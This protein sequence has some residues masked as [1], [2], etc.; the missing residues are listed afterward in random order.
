ML[1]TAPQAGI[2]ANFSAW[3]ME[4]IPGWEGKGR[5]MA[6]YTPWY[7]CRGGQVIGLGAVQRAASTTAAIQS[8]HRNAV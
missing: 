2:V 8:P 3:F 4:A 1:P 7:K 5:A 6:V